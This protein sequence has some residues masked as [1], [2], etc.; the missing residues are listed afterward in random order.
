M[1][2][3]TAPAQEGLNFSDKLA[4]SLQALDNILREKM[5]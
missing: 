1:T 5:V 3:G 2:L 4:P